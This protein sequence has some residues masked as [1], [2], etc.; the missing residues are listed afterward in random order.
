[1]GTLQTQ[2]KR[3]ANNNMVPIS[4]VKWGL[5]NR[6]SDGIELSESL[7]KYPD[8]QGAILQHELGHHKSNTFKQDLAHDLTPINKL[9]QIDLL[10]FMFKHPK[11]LTQFLPVYWSPKRKQL[12][13]DLNMVIIYSFIFGTIGLLLIFL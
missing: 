2:R 13:Y 5:A 1:L 10:I 12:I 3:K 9:S 8:L 7:K 4:Y 11:T 6:F